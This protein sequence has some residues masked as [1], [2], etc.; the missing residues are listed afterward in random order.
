[1]ATPN[2]F[3]QTGCP[4]CNVDLSCAVNNTTG[5]ICDSVL[6]PATQGVSYSETSSF[7][8]PK[9]TMTP[10]GMA[11]LELV[12]ILNVQGLP[13]GINWECDSSANGCN[14]YPQDMP[15][16]EEL[17]CLRFC[18]TTNAAPGV[19][20][21][22]TNIQIIIN[23]FVPITVDTSYLNQLVV[24]PPGPSCPET[25]NPPTST[26]R[27]IPCS[28]FNVDSCFFSPSLYYSRTSCWRI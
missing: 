22:V 17:G 16:G 6:A 12:H 3:A 14:Y 26:D 10:F 28:K 11:P 20:P 13:A 4:G 1:M 25:A 23:P 7:Y 19:Y 24:L 27:Y 18:G 2:L 9:M 21:I 8:M 5:G 15:V